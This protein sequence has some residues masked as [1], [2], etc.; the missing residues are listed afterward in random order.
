[1]GTRST[2]SAVFFLACA[3]VF[4]GCNSG[5]D[6]PAYADPCAPSAEAAPEDVSAPRTVVGTG[7]PASCTG[8]A[9]V[10]A[11]ANGGVITFDCGPEPVTITL[12]TTAIVIPIHTIAPRM[13]KIGTP[14][15]LACMVVRRSP[16]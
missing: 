5:S 11:V 16:V 7:T 2:A 12:T 6:E 14:G 8:D 13:M 4:A 10:Q 1:M 15:G 9:F 3:S